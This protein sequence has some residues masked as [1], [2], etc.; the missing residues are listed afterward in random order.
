MKDSAVLRQNPHA[1]AAEIGDEVVFLH[2]GDGVYY[3]LDGV[4]AFVWT[5]LDAP[6]SFND[7]LRLV[8]A[9]YDV[10]EETCRRDLEEL[11]RILH[12]KDLIRLD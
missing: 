12:E 11:V 10:G 3:G 1:A 9:E 5:L 7:I 2:E 8:L 6:R 4:G